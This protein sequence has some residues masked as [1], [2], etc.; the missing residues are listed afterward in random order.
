MMTEISSYFAPFFFFFRWASSAPRCS[1]GVRPSRWCS[2]SCTLQSG[3]SRRPPRYPRLETVPPFPSP[4]ACA[5]PPSA[6]ARSSSA[7][8]PRACAG[9]S[10]TFECE[11]ISNASRTRRFQARE[12][13]RLSLGVQLRRIRERKKGERTQAI[14]RCAAIVL[15]L[16]LVRRGEEVKLK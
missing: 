13:Q 10:S 5:G 7:T 15:V 3:P 4:I 12:V 2:G 8:W 16:V 1:P 11:C 14:G 9:S 6:S